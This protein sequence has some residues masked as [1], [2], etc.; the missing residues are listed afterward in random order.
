MIWPAY[1][2]RPIKYLEIILM[3]WYGWFEG[4]EAKSAYKFF[5]HSSRLV[6]QFV[7]VF[8]RKLLYY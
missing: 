3:L 2:K 4:H 8:W 7:T 5:E 6:L 1:S